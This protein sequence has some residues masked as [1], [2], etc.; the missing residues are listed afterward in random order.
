MSRIFTSDTLYTVTQSRCW[1]L[2]SF[3]DWYVDGGRQR[4][5]VW[6]GFW[7]LGWGLCAGGRLSWELPPRTGCWRCNLGNTKNTRLCLAGD[8]LYIS[9]TLISRFHPWPFTNQYILIK[10]SKNEWAG[11]FHI[12]RMVIEGVSFPSLKR[13]SLSIFAY[14]SLGFGSLGVPSTLAHFPMVLSQPTMLFKTQEWSWKNIGRADKE[15]VNIVM[16]LY[17]GLIW[18]LDKSD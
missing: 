15:A 9:I 1:W 5:R 7:S 8:V 10:T 16:D 6:F 13:V 11:G 4:T 3:G 18:S 12:P 14:G 2:S 17:T